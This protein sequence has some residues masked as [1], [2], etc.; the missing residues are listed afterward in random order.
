MTV[1]GDLIQS[2]GTLTIDSGTLIV[3]GNY[4]MQ[5]LTDGTYG[6]SSGALNMRDSD[7]VIII[8][9]D[10]ILQT[11]STSHYLNAGTIYMKGNI[12]QIT[13]IRDIS[14]FNTGT[15]L[16]VVMTADK[17]HTLRFEDSNNNSLGWLT[18]E[19]DVTA[20]QTEQHHVN[21]LLL[22]AGA[23]ILKKYPRQ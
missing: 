17:S 16:N 8:D 5:S 18:L 4:R 1:N 23:A 6:D 7:G 10:L 12:N 22:L 11:T 9:G 15:G 21:C 13:P 14:R 3:H 19:N 20:K 2:G